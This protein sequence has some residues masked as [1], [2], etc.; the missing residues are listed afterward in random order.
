MADWL[1]STGFQPV[2]LSVL[3][4][5]SEITGWKPVLR[6]HTEQPSRGDAGYTNALPVSYLSCRVYPRVPCSEWLTPATQVGVR[7]DWV[8]VFQ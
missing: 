7:L 4:G 2:I 6:S 8:G 3:L 5:S 1:R